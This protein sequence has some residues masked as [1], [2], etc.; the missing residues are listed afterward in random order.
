MEERVYQIPFAEKLRRLFE[1]HYPGVDLR[2]TPVW[3]AGDILL[4]YGGDFNKYITSKRLQ[5][6]EGVVFR[7]LLRLIQLIEEF[8][9]L[10]P[11]DY[12]AR[13]WRA[14]LRELR[15]KLEETCRNV[16]PLSVDETINRSKRRDPLDQK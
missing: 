9:P 7:H 16:D 14:E 2:V 8:I 6:Q 4:R 1:Y 11:A 13:R 3:A 12:D 10:N 15:D 5:T